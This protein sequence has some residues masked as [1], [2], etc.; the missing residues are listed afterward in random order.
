MSCY[1]LVTSIWILIL[2]QFLLYLGVHSNYNIYLAWVTLW[3]ILMPCFWVCQH[4]IMCPI[5]WVK[6]E[7]LDLCHQMLIF[8]LLHFVTLINYIFT[9]LSY[10]CITNYTDVVIS[11]I[12][13][14]SNI[15]CRRHQCSPVA[16]S[17]SSRNYATVY[18]R[19]NCKP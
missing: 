9:L 10:F 18:S 19:K 1:L 4:P 14:F 6:W 13:M 3:F 11:N 5:I 17:Q 12:A 7:Q 15:A 16:Q 8:V 2:F